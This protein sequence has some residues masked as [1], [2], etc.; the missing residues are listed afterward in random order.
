M[1]PTKKQSTH[2]T[3]ECQAVFNTAHSN[4][5][6]SAKGEARREL[7]FIVVL[8]DTTLMTHVVTITTL[9]R[10]KTKNQSLVGW[11][12][13]YEESATTSPLILECRF[14]STCLEMSLTLRVLILALCE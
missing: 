5:Q 12:Q 4:V 7:T 3:Y 13:T 8:E 14:A 6:E 11:D 1:T 2:D 9:T 10:F